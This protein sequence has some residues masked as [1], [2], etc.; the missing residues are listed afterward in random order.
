MSLTVLYLDLSMATFHFSQ[1]LFVAIN[2][3]AIK[4]PSLCVFYM[5]NGRR[6]PLYLHDLVTK[7]LIIGIHAPIP[8]REVAI[9]EVTEYPTMG[10]IIGKW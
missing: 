9:T 4:L 5:A 10:L 2:S 7:L 3:S 1:L 6:R 8:C